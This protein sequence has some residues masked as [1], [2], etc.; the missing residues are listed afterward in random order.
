MR[1]EH[2]R[3]C[4]F[5]IDTIVPLAALLLSACSTFTSSNDREKA[6][7]HYNNARSYLNNR[8][9]ER[10]ADQVRRGLVYDESHYGLR[11][12]QG[13]LQAIAGRNDP[14]SYE[15]ALQT[16]DELRDERSDDEHDYRLL[17]LSGQAHQGL[18]LAHR[19]AALALERE[20]ES[21]SP[22][23]ESTPGDIEQKRARAA[24]HRRELVR[25]MDAAE[26]DYERL[27][28]RDGEGKFPALER[29]FVLETDR[30]TLLE[31]EARRLQLERAAARAEEYLALNA[32][33]QE[34]YSVMLELTLEAEQEALGR[35][36][37]RELRRRERAFRA[38]YANLLFDLGK[39]DKAREQL[40]LVIA[41]DPTIDAN[42][43]NRARCLIELGRKSAAKRDLQDF[44]RMT[45]LAYDS[46]RVTEANQLLQDLRD[47]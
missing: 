40:D 47:A 8:D 13:W 32:Y 6:D 24:E 27:A 16:F 43:Y 15:R 9:Y 39:W 45:K 20:I 26:K 23:G 12:M 34:H 4:R 19:R 22:S 38:T 35:E 18:Y 37:R 7:D 14:R 36:T 30:A 1:R 29:L 31:G 5:S 21:T 17:L 3:S 44:L 10:S 42:Y 25:H 33:R 11:L 41:I 46:P 28:S 2:R